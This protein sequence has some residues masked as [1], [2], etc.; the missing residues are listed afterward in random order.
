MAEY[1][2]YYPVPLTTPTESSNLMISDS[3]YPTSET[4]NLQPGTPCPTSQTMVYVASISQQSMTSLPSDLNTYN[5]LAHPLPNAPQG[6]IRVMVSFRLFA[7]T[8]H[9]STQTNFQE[10]KKT[11]GMVNSYAEVPVKVTVKVTYLEAFRSLVINACNTH[12]GGAGTLISKGL[13]EVTLLLKMENPL[14]VAKCA[15]RED[16]LSAQELHNAAIRDTS[17]KQKA[18]DS[19]SGLEGSENWTPRIGILSTF[20]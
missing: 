1:F 17:G 4:I 20:I 5:H 13:S 14:K 7:T 15:Q 2:Y 6:N 9:H 8:K 18:T 19:N 3:P 16:L 11:W 10:K 12:F